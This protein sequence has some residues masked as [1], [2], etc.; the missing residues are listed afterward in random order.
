[1]I[2]KYYKIVEAI[3]FD[4]TNWQELVDWWEANKEEGTIILPGLKDAIRVGDYLVNDN[5]EFYVF[6]KDYFETMYKEMK[7]ND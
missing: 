7:N 3:Q 6:N 4:G 2:K 1:M 5:G